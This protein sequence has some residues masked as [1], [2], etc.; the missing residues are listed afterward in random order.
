MTDLLLPKKGTF[1]KLVIKKDNKLRIVV[2][3]GA[4]MVPVDFINATELE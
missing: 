4:T 3:D 1:R 2:V